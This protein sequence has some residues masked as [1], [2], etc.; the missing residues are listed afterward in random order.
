MSVAAP[1]V[2]TV[3]TTAVKHW[4]ESLAVFDLETTGIDVTTSRIVSANVGVLDKDG[5]V[6]RRRDWIADPGVE[7]PGEATA[8]H[9]ITTEFAQSV[10]RSAPVVVREIVETLRELFD[11][12]TPVVIYNAPYDLSL[13]FNEALRHGI[14][15]LISPMPVIDPLV[16][17]KALDKYRKGKRT[18]EAAAEFYGVELTDAHDAGADAIAA[19]RV[20]QAIARAHARALDIDVLELHTLQEGW[21]QEQSDSF[22]D[23]IRRTRDATYVA[24][25]GWPVR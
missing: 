16:I 24:S 21:C 19:G 15:P 18:L 17:D 4:S 9:G 1:R 11:A 20:A 13:L 12:G 25:A 22:Q 3:E 23:Y 14:P 10:G 6:L 7:I 8:V 5:T 2:T